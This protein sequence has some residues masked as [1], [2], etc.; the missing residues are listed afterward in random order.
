MC[1]W[2]HLPW[3]LRLRVLD[4]VERAPERHNLAACAAVA[5][6]WQA[7]VERRTFS[8][9][10][11]HSKEIDVFAA[12]VEGPQKSV[13]LNYIR[14]LHLHVRL[15]MYNCPNCLVP[16]SPDTVHR[17]NVEFTRALWALLAVLATHNSRIGDDRLGQQHGLTLELSA[18]SF[19]DA[20]HTFTDFRCQRGYPR[21]RVPADLDPAYTAYTERMERRRHAKANQHSVIRRL[22][23]PYAQL[24]LQRDAFQSPWTLKAQRVMGGRPLALDF[25]NK[26]SDSSSNGGGG[27]LCRI[28]IVRG[29]VIRRQFYRCI[30]PDVLML[31]LNPG[32][33]C[34]RQL[35]IETWR[36]VLPFALRECINGYARLLKGLPRQLDAFHLHIEHHRRVPYHD[37][38]W[39]HLPSALN[40]SKQLVFASRSLV[41]VSVSYTPADA[42]QFL[43]MV[44]GMPVCQPDGTQVDVNWPAGEPRQW[45]RLQTLALNTA[46][47]APS[48]PWTLGEQLLVCAADTA[49]CMPALTVMELWNPFAGEECY[50]QFEARTIPPKITLRAVWDARRVW[51]DRC[52]K[53]WSRVA[54]MHYPNHPLEVSIEPLAADAVGPEQGYTGVLQHLQLRDKIVDPVSY[55]QMQWEE[56]HNFEG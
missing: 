32:L 12:A 35:R 45:P 49:A 19:S 54:N 3:E 10:D 15:G 55:Y 41:H 16:E 8:Y 18:A 14:H 5:A 44:A 48:M 33:R 21:F 23:R 4:Y 20:H 52:R 27:G 36:P 1:S 56:A 22:T 40:L 31:L 2:Q 38:T 28:N 51:T 6:E 29:L 17:N 11:V 34:I 9:L 13:R 42:S 7:P 25:G 53:R 26:G 39:A 50:V 30:S 43:S 46:T 24:H 47:L 37:E